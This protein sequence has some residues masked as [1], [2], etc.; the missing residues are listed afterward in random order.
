MNAVTHGLSAKQIIIPGEKPEQF[1]K[2]RDGLIA[3]F[4]PRSTIER[5]LIRRSSRVLAASATRASS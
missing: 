5:E 2:L 4:A 3:D 1:Y